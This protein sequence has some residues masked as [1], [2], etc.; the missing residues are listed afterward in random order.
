M[1]TGDIL[2][3][4][5]IHE[6]FSAYY[7][8]KFK[9]PFKLVRTT[10]DQASF[11]DLINCINEVNKYLAK[12][13]LNTFS[14]P[15]NL[16]SQQAL[17]RLHE[18]WVKLHIAH[19]N[20]PIL[21]NKIEPSLKT[22]LDN[23]NSFIHD[24]ESQFEFEFQSY[25]TFVEQVDNIF[26]TK[27]LQFGKFDIRVEYNNL[28]RSSYNKWLMQ[29]NNA[30]DIDTNNYMKS[31]GSFI[32]DLGTRHYTSAAPKEYIEYCN[33]LNIDPVADILPLGNVNDYDLARE[34]VARN[35]N[36]TIILE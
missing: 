13:N 7:V 11:K 27:L 26:G 10:F 25:D 17:N 34:L 18:Q 2:E 8:S 20:L 35:I 1:T 16:Y 9:R 32:V 21:F 12:C 22:M 19:S 24:I 15:E 28:G 29:D 31:G 14:I 5:P 33:S 4:S 6:E 30:V 23:I 36:D 3:F